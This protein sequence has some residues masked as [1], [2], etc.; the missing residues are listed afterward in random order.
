MFEGRKLVIAT[1]HGK[2]RVIA[3]L[4]EKELGVSCMLPEHFNSDSLGTFTGEKEREDDPLTTA[5]KK[6]I[7]AMEL[8]GCDLGIANEG[9]FGPH[10]SLYF[11]GA[12]DELILFMDKKNNLEIIAREISTDT[13]FSYK[14]IHNEDE[15]LDFA[16]KVSF[17]SHGLIL[18]NARESNNEIVKGITNQTHLL[19][20]YK[21][22]ASKYGVVCVETDMRALYNPTRMLV[23]EKVTIKLIEKIK[24]CCPKC[25]T[26]GFGIINVKS[27]LKC[28]LCGSPTRSILAHIYQCTHCGFSEEKM[29]PHKKH[30]EDPMYCDRCNP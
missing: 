4:L 26:P 5:R 6:C 12:D 11:I 20:T 23:I 22:M 18:R 3:P 10:P 30:T 1:M 25:Q 7:L 8:T 19:E 24:S 29:Y 21:S 17:P 16:A 28:D 13:N 27:G 9:S 15:L 2:E 14:E